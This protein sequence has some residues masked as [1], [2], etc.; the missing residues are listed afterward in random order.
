MRLILRRLVVA[1]DASKNNYLNNCRLTLSSPRAQQ[2]QTTRRSLSSSSS[3]SSSKSEWWSSSNNDNAVNVIQGPNLLTTST[4]RPS[5]S[6]LFLPGLRSLPLWTRNSSTEPTQ[7]AFSD[8]GLTALVE[9]LEGHAEE[10]KDEYLDKNSSDTSIESDYADAD[11]HDKLHEGVWKWHSYMTKGQVCHNFSPFATYFPRTKEILDNLR[12]QDP[13]LLFEDLPFGFSFL[14]TLEGN[15]SIAPHSSPMNLR[16]R[17]HLP[18]IVPSQDSKECGIQVGT[19]VQPWTPGKCMILD[20]SYPHHVWNQTQDKRV[21][22]LLD[23]WHPDISKP[24][25]EEI[26]TMFQQAKEQGLWKV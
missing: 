24:E 6:L 21:L 10:M 12:E 25:R 16:L 11:G 23:I 2:Q 19:Q 15:G 26:R 20:D 22:L 13:L 18:L 4:P 8:P 7:V 14:S 5:P 9:Y 17:I 3:G 1:A